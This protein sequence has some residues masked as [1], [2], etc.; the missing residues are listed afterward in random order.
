[1]YTIISEA[2]VLRSARFQGT[3]FIIYNNSKLINSEFLIYDR[4]IAEQIVNKNK[5]IAFSSIANYTDV[6]FNTSSKLNISTC[7][8]YKYEE[9]IKSKI[10]Y[11]LLPGAFTLLFLSVFIN[12]SLIYLDII[13]ILVWDFIPHKWI[14]ILL[15]VAL[16]AFSSAKLGFSFFA[17]HNDC[18]NPITYFEVFYYVYMIY[19]VA[20]LV[21]WTVL[22]V[23]L[24][25]LIVHGFRSYL[26][27]E[28]VK[29]EPKKNGKT[30]LSLM[31]K[32]ITGILIIA[33]VGI[34]CCGLI[35]FIIFKIIWLLN[36]FKS[37]IPAITSILSIAGGVI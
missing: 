10:I 6:Q 31:I 12:T 5:S 30:L 26:N 11:K 1:M 19:S 22:I 37:L 17:L 4:I 2:I 28:G 27:K 33:G 34:L 25:V 21:V 9:I 20:Y 7:Y 35:G 16:K 36:G 18:L 24:I 23:L 14:N 29:E 13:D 8:E 3:Q 15:S 32:I